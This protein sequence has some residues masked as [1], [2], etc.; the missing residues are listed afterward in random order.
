MLEPL[1]DRER[2]ILELINQGMSN[3]AIADTL[4]LSRGTVKAHSH[5][6]YNKLGVT[7]RVQAVLKAQELGLLEAASAP[8]PA[9]KTAGSA[10]AA[11]PAPPTALNLPSQLTPFIGRKNELNRLKDILDDERVR[12]VTILGAGGMGKT[13]LALEMLRQAAPDY[14]DGAFFISLARVSDTKNLAAAVIDDLGLRIQHGA[15]PEQQLVNYL[16]HKQMLLVLDNF[17]HLLEG[18]ALLTEAMYAAPG[19]RLLVTS[20]ERLNLSAEVVF[21]LGGMDYKRHP[22]TADFIEY[23][24]AQLLVER[25]QAV[26]PM[27]ELQPDDWAHVHRICQLT[28]GMPLALVL[29]AGWLDTLS[30]KET[31]NGLAQS[32]DFLESQYRDLPARQRSMRATVTSSWQRLSPEEQQI[33]A[34]LSVFR[35]SF[36]RDAAQK[37]AGTTLRDLQTLVNRSFVIFSSGRYELHQLLR[38]FAE[39][40]LAREPD[41]YDHIHNLH[42][43]YYTHFLH[44]HLY[45]VYRIR[46]PQVIA[47]IR[48]SLDNIRAAWRW[49]VEHAR[50]DALHR[51]AETVA[52]FLHTQGRYAEGVEIFSS[53]LETLNRTP[54]SDERDLLIAIMST[55]MGWYYIRLGRMDEAEAIFKQSSATFERLGFPHLI[56][57]TDPLVGLALIASIRG[58]YEEATHIAELCLEQNRRS[59]HAS[60]QAYTFYALTGIKLAQGYYEQARDCG[61]QAA[62][63]ASSKEVQDQWLLAYCLIELGNVARAMGDLTLAANYYRQSYDIKHQFDDPEG[64]AL[65]SS[66]LGQLALQQADF[67]EAEHLYQHSL[68]AYEQIQ[69]QGGLATA[70]HGLAQVALSSGDYPACRDYLRQALSTASRIEY[71]PLLFAILLTVADMRLHTEQTEQGLALLNFVQQHPSSSQETRSQARQ[72]FMDHQLAGPAPDVPQGDLLAIVSAIQAELTSLSMPR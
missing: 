72:I 71:I 26:H 27:F 46:N 57:T 34:S 23:E 9:H 15:K 59:Q 61:Q 21:V 40:E 43:D 41:T 68:H 29:A 66:L 42:C 69:D 31:A 20:R 11:E 17:E 49:A 5:N 67:E 33:F 1:T 4:Y 3:Q 45:D 39:S 36:T 55:D 62:A 12:L 60:N 13:R 19:V 18:V 14:P 16:Q 25:A 47:E 64:I 50:V 48:L 35:G 8:A 30:L 10:S 52:S 54:S 70:L 6:I 22:E 37:V 56:S 65:I 2:E 58:S 28:G 24:A 38:Q 7:S 51:A 32:I 44:D 63:L 53:A